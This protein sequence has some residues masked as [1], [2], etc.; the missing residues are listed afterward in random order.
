MPFGARTMFILTRDN[1][2]YSSQPAQQM[3]RL[4]AL[5]TVASSIYFLSD[6][7]AVNL[8]A[9][10]VLVSAYIYFERN[11]KKRRL[12]A[13]IHAIQN[14]QEDKASSLIQVMQS[15]PGEG[16]LNTQNEHG[17]NP[18]MHALYAHASDKIIKS[19][20]HA[21]Q[22]QKMA[23]HFN[24][25]NEIGINAL[26]CAYHVNASY[27]S[28]QLL[29]QAMKKTN[30][31]FNAQDPDGWT[32]L[33]FAFQY[34]AHPQ[35]INLLIEAMKETGADFAAQ[36]DRGW[37]ALTFA[38]EYNAA[39][40]DVTGRHHGTSPEAIRTLHVNTIDA[41]LTLGGIKCSKKLLQLNNLQVKHANRGL[42]YTIKILAYLKSTLADEEEGMP[43]ALNDSEIPA[44]WYFFL[45]NITQN[46]TLI[47]EAGKTICMQLVHDLAY[48]QPHIRQETAKPKI[49]PKL[50]FPIFSQ[51]DLA[52][53]KQ[54]FL[55]PLKASLSLAAT[56]KKLYQIV[57][58]ILF[59]IWEPPQ[60]QHFLTRHAMTLIPKVFQ[61][62]KYAQY[63]DTKGDPDPLKK[64][65]V[66]FLSEVI[67][68]PNP[69]HFFPLSAQL[70]PSE[71][72]ETEN[73]LSTMPDEI[74]KKI[75]NISTWSCP[76]AWQITHPFK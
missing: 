71:Q 15:Q 32:A 66:H 31:N 17:W 10:C 16:G 75:L 60:K 23:V 53:C 24:H 42:Y 74:T 13:L 9:D 14:Q 47:K 19:L 43:P 63:L 33:M 69:K 45:N 4:F 72:T 48:F 7:L 5:A 2:Q 54:A 38:F 56:S 21:M 28:I 12:D 73:G 76:S 40:P 65:F 37:A 44:A 58:T 61:S 29:I 50:W 18:L 59:S 41:L 20:I 11:I 51:C 57:R 22:A 67:L 70:N 6:A 62:E 39:S 1:I 3:L 26:M 8:S 34:G 36:D 52:S 55:S 27:Q 46:D 30:A 49:P 64:S 68:P 35:S 25:K